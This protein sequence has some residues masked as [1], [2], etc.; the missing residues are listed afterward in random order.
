[1]LASSVIS[2]GSF[3]DQWPEAQTRAVSCL[4]AKPNLTHILMVPLEQMWVPALAVPHSTALRT[5]ALCAQG[6]GMTLA[7]GI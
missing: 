1:M 2:F 3:Q 5:R 4:P 6:E 7:R